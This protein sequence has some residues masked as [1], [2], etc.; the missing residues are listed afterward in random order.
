MVSALRVLSTGAGTAW[1]PGRPAGGW[2]LGR[3][4]GTGLMFNQP[5]PWIQRTDIGA[6]RPRLCRRWDPWEGSPSLLAH[7]LLK[8]L[9][10]LPRDTY[11]REAVSIVTKETNSGQLK[12]GG[13]AGMSPPAG[14]GEGAGPRG[15]VLV[16]QDT[17]TPTSPGMIDS[18]LGL[19]VAPQ[20][21]LSSDWGQC[22]RL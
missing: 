12:S 13:Q 17:P 15:P 22:P 14:G 3:P 16:V 20:A 2:G 5:Q 11:S 10:L 6:C 7:L 1:L 18:P 8:L 21:L 19:S 4:A 9:E